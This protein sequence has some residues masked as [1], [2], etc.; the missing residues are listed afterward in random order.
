MKK[1][2]I[3]VS[4]LFFI[5]FLV[6]AFLA[7]S[8]WRFVAAGSQPVYERSDSPVAEMTPVA[9]LQAGDVASVN[10][11][12]FDKADAYIKVQSDSKEGRFYGYVFTP[13]QEYRR[14]WSWKDVHFGGQR[15]MSASTCLRMTWQFGK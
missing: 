14:S 13:R 2:F 3:F 4:F 7:G 1:L 12:F 9:V 15:L 11:C 8:S 6:W 10:E 5:G